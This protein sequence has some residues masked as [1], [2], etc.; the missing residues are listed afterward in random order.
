MRGRPLEEFPLSGELPRRPR[1]LRCC[2]HRPGIA[3]AMH[4]AAP[5]PGVRVRENGDPTPA[6][7]VNTSVVSLV[8]RGGGR[9]VVVMCVVSPRIPACVHEGD[10]VC[11]RAAAHPI[12]EP[13]SHSCSVLPAC[14]CLPG[15]RACLFCFCEKVGPPPHPVP[16]AG[17]GCLGPL[18]RFC[19]GPPT[20]IWCGPDGK[21][22]PFRFYFSQGFPRGPKASRTGQLHLPSLQYTAGNGCG[23]G[24]PSSTLIPEFVRP[25]PHSPSLHI[26]RVPRNHAQ[27]DAG[28]V[29]LSST[30]PRHRHRRSRHGC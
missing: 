9:M 11:A 10:G 7:G 12:N 26:H 8:G 23:G 21:T 6:A 14:S 5:G 3:C 1:P 29:Q 25:P 30:P 22:G 28:A 13:L 27:V 15:M 2:L 18:S 24:P 19:R 4:G 17:I 16:A 20:Q